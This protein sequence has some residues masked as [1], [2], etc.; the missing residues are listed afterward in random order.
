VCSTE[1]RDYTQSLSQSLS[2]SGFLGLMH[3]VLLRPSPLPFCTVP[4]PSWTEG[5]AGQALTGCSCA[6]LSEMGA[7]R[8]RCEPPGTLGRSVP[9]LRG[10]ERTHRYHILH[11]QEQ[12]HTLRRDR[13]QNQSSCRRETATSSCRGNESLVKRTRFGPSTSSS[14]STPN[15]H[16]VAWEE[17][18]TSPTRWG[19]RRSVDARL[20]QQDDRE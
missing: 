2:L 15:L 19:V 18:A 13:R 14:N 11:E 1:A 9:P 16:Y 20:F 4:E 12:G 3:F 10:W 17:S 7:R 8:K 5:R 6:I